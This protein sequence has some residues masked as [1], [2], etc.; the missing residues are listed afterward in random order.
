MIY[1]KQELEQISLEDQ[2]IAVSRYLNKLLKNEI[3]KLLPHEVE[4]ITSVLPHVYSNSDRTV[5]KYDIY[6]LDFCNESLFKKL[7][8]RYLLNLDFLSPVYNGYKNLSKE[9]ILRDKIKFDYLLS[10]WEDR[11][12]S[13]G[14]NDIF[15]HEIKIEYNRKNK[16]L[17]LLRNNNQFVGGRFFYE[18]KSLNEKLVAFYIYYTVKL[19]FKSHRSNSVIFEKNGFR[20]SIN[21]YSYIHIISRHYMQSVNI[22]DLDKSFNNELSIIDV[23]NLPYSIRDLIC[24]YIRYAPDNYQLKEF[25]IFKYNNDYY[26]IWLKLKKMIEFNNDFA[27]EVRTMYKI[28]K[29]VDLEKVNND[30]FYKVDENISYF[31]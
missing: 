12:H 27:Y 16:H 15:L 28:F 2:P 29:E 1:S 6:E 24:E 30:T 9:E 31:Y 14:S 19:F 22:V 10:I 4:F 13:K 8:L 21:V 7:I 17:K 18:R 25:I 5:L 26:I 11:L 23:F 3:K 20:F